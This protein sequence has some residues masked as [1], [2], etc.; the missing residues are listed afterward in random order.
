ME[1]NINWLNRIGSRGELLVNNAVELATLLAVSSFVK[2]L[3]YQD[4]K[5]SSTVGKLDYFLLFILCIRFL[6]F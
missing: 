1:F 6:S 4:K 2:P 5:K 3:N